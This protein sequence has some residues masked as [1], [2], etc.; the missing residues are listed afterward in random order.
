MRQ[1]PLAL[2]LILY[3]RRHSL[4]S[5]YSPNLPYCV[6]LTI[7]S[8]NKLPMFYIGSSSVEKIKNGYRGSVSS[9]Q[10]KSIWKKELKENPHLFKTKII[11]C[12][13]DRKLAVIKENSLHKFLNVVKSPFYVNQ[14]NAIPDGIYGQSMKGSNN[15][16]FGK[17]RTMS[18]ETKKKISES[19]K[20]VLK[21]EQTKQKMRKPKPDTTKYF[22]NKN[23]VGKKPWLG[24]KHSEETKKK[25]SESLRLKNYL[26]RSQSVTLI[27]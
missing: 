7:Y 14:S 10:Y 1:H 4:S 9:K 19:T 25:I 26:T 5:I 22:G 8:G 23:A 20:G 15:P 2:C 6:Y 13:G 3:H 27:K 17:K 24:K 11:S 18:E 21:S 12:Y 16:M